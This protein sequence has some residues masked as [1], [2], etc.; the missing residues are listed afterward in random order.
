M[1]TI[2]ASILKASI[3]R[4]QAS[5]LVEYEKSTKEL[6]TEIEHFKKEEQKYQDTQKGN[7]ELK[8]KN[9]DLQREL[10]YLRTTLRETE[11]SLRA[12]KLRDYQLTQIE[13]VCPSLKTHFNAKDKK[14][15]GNTLAMRIF[16][17]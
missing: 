15:K 3:I 10:T 9:R 6:K 11:R 17:N 7:S 1:L 5:K 4:A 13:K 14:R 12:L 16:N 8:H 2:I